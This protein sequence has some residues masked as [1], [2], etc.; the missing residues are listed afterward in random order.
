MNK[1]LLII[2]W[3]YV[4]HNK[5]EVSTEHISLDPRLPHPKSFWH[6]QELS[7]CTRSVIQQWYQPENN[8]SNDIFVSHSNKYILVRRQDHL[9][10]K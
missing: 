5:N 8:S 1:W 4:F 7:L 9:T 3:F 10:R 2:V 6:L